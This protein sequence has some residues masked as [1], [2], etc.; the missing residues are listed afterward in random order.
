MWSSG[1]E[2][3]VHYRA[4]APID[5]KKG[6]IS[7]TDNHNSILNRLL[8]LLLFIL[9]RANIGSSLHPPRQEAGRLHLGSAALFVARRKR[10]RLLEWRGHYGTCRTP[11]R[12]GE[13]TNRGRAAEP[14][15]AYDET[16]SIREN[17]ALAR[18]VKDAGPPERQ[19]TLR[20]PSLRGTAEITV[21][22]DSKSL[23]AIYTSDAVHAPLLLFWGSESDDLKGSD[24]PTAL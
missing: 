24:L 3:S 8:K 10:W 2:F 11:G 18:R 17:T 7:K 5:V 1:G 9:G 6:I 16:V 14:C 21:A 4:P 22:G 15:M 13:S 19:L 20:G 12:A 23:T